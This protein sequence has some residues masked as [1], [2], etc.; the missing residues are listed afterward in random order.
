MT[1]IGKCD[2]TPAFKSSKCSIWPIQCQVIELKPEVRKKHILMSALWFGPSKPSMLILLTSFTKKASVLETEG[3][4]WQDNQENYHV[5]KV[6]VL[7]CSS[8]SMA[9]PLFLNTKQFNSFYGCNFC[10]HKGGKS[11]P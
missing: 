2:G 6:F 8:D 3:V 9:C 4:D 5:S 1:L 10:Y 7:V 11:Y